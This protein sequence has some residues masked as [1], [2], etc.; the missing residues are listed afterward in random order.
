M[1]TAHEPHH[2]QPHLQPEQRDRDYE[3]LRTLMQERIDAISPG[4]THLFVTDIGPRPYDTFLNALPPEMRQHHVCHTCR[5]FVERF[6]ALV[7]VTDDLLIPVMWPVLP[8]NNV[9]QPAVEAMARLVR[10]APIIGVHVS[11]E[12]TWGIPIT[13]DWTHFAVRPPAR[14]ITKRSRLETASQ[15]AAKLAHEAETL[16]TGLREY[17]LELVQRAHML[18]TTGQLYRSEKCIGTAAWLLD[19][20]RQLANVRG[21]QRTNLI[22]RAAASAPV[23]FCHVKSTMIGTLLDDLAANLP[24][25]DVKRKFDAKMNPLQYQRPTAAPTLGNILQAEKIVDALGI[26]AS[27]ERRFAKL[28][29]V[30]ALWVPRA[31]TREPEPT[32]GVFDHLRPLASRQ[33]SVRDLGT[34]P[35]LMTWS[36][37]RRDI[38]ASAE[39]IELLVPSVRAPFT[40]MVTAADPS[41]PP[42][43]QWD[44]PEQRN[45]MSMYVYHGGSL[46]H[47]WGLSPTTWCSV[48]AITNDPA[49]WYGRQSPNH[50]QR[51]YL[52]LQGARDLRHDHG[53]GF[54]PETLRSELHQ[55]RATLEAHALRVKIAGLNEAT[56][57]GLVFG[58]KS[59]AILLRVVAGGLRQEYRI[60]R[61]E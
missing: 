53:G 7:V 12:S 17:G 31:S 59:P 22:W 28:E 34:P 57:C 21:A 13:G 49:H 5:H 10:R 4:V 40:A 1:L 54:F 43:L 56:A 29:D 37:F 52:L 2:H 41:A 11:H 3:V 61:L 32:G 27:L 55:I 42:I 19:V 9:Y 58:D 18:L 48:T 14:F 39:T 51:V 24:F 60:D 20:H 6:G 44:A 33:P 50:A 35:T 38:L 8:A 36:K 15:I 26:R 47:H 30:E 45:P 23:G 46:A 25:A 16:T